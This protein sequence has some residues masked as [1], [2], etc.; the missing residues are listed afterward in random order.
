MIGC[1]QKLIAFCSG[2]QKDPKQVSLSFTSGDKELWCLLSDI[3]R[4]FLTSLFLLAYFHL[5]WV[6]APNQHRCENIFTKHPSVLTYQNVI[7]CTV[8]DANAFRVTESSGADFLQK[9]SLFFELVLFVF[10]HTELSWVCRTQL[11]SRQTGQP[12]PLRV[13]GS[14]MNRLKW[15][16]TSN[17]RN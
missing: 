6:S 1:V 8:L 9:N 17:T 2:Y 16:H 4:D 14:D 11:V 3:F 10:C 5:N 7:T 15:T 13:D 12:P